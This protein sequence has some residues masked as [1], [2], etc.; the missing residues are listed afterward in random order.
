MSRSPRHPRR[1]SEVRA[2]EARAGELNQAAVSVN[3]SPLPTAA[4]LVRQILILLMGGAP[5]WVQNVE[6]RDDKTLCVLTE[7]RVFEVTVR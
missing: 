4:D 2:A 6:Q 1:P 7:G 3:K 5:P